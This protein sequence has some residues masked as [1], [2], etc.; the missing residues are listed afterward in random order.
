M[1]SPP[2]PSAAAPA[3]SPE[4]INARIAR[5]R[6]EHDVAEQNL[7]RSL[8][9]HEIGALEELAGDASAA[10]REQLDAVNVEPEFHEPLERLI[11]L[12]RRSGSS[13][14]VGKLL[15]RLS[16]VSEGADERARALLD[17]AAH[18][19]DVDCD[20]EAARVA[21]E[22]AAEEKPNEPAVFL[23]LE[24]VAA[25]LKDD[26]LRLR[27]LAARADLCTHPTWATLLLLD[28]AELERAQGDDEAALG[29]IEQALEKK[30]AATFR[31]LQA[32]EAHAQTTG[33]DDLT[34]RALEAQAQLIARSMADEKLGDA[35]GVP[36]YRRQ[37][38][39]AADASLR[40]AEAH[41]RRG[42]VA[43]A[44]TLLDQALGRITDEPALTHA[45]LV[46]AELMGDTQKSAE[47]ALSELEQG[48]KGPIAASLWLRV[49]EAA[50]TDGDAAR[51]IEAVRKALAEDPGSIAARVLELDLLGNG[52]DPQALATAYEAAAES[53]S[54]D[55][56][57]AR[58]FLLAADA[59]AR[60][61][62]DAPGAKAALSQAGMYGAS[63]LV[64]ARTTRM[65]ATLM[66]DVAWYEEGSR[67]LVAAHADPAEQVSVWFE[68]SRLRMLRQD[69][70]QHAAL[71]SLSET[72]HG[73]WLGAMLRAFVAPLAGAGKP[74]DPEAALA[75]LATISDAQTSRAIRVTLAL[76]A[77]DAKQTDAAEQLLA[78]L[79]RED[80][81]DVLT[82]SAL[83]ALTR[84]AGRPKD[85]AGVLATCASGCEDG[86]LSA[87]LELEAGILYWQA[88]ERSVAVEAFTRA[89]SLSPSAGGPVLGWALRAADPDNLDSRRRALEMTGEDDDGLSALERFGV[90]AGTGGDRLAA[91]ELVEVLNGSVEQ[92]FRNAALLAHALIGEQDARAQALEALIAFGGTTEAAARGA[93]H[94]RALGDADADAKLRTAESWA[95][96]DPA[97]APALEW[98]GAAYG[99]GNVEK[100]LE[101]RRTLA[102]RLEGPARLGVRASA[103]LCSYLGGNGSEPLLAD[104]DGKEQLTVRLTN[105]ELAPP[106]CDPRRRASALA[107]VEGAFGDESAAMARALAGW[108]LLASDD[109]DAAVRAFRSAV[110]AYPQELIGW[111]GLRVAADMMRDLP[112]LAEASAALGDAVHDDAR[113]AELWEQ[114]AFI[115]LDELRDPARAEF[116]LSRAVERDITRFKSFDKLFR[117]VREKKD[118]TRLLDLI[119][120]R[121]EVAED[122][123]EIAK[124]YWER[125]RVLRTAGDREGALDALENVVLLEPDHVGALALSGEIHLT[126][127]N[128]PE[129]AE[130]LARLSTLSEA[131]AKQ[132]LMS[133]VAAVD[134][135]ENKLGRL[136]QA[137]LVL[138]GLY[139][140]GLSTLPV[141]ERF[142][143]AA[144]KAESWRQA[145]EVLEQLMGER[146]TSEGRVEAAR[147]AMAIYR[148]R[149]DEPASAAAVIERLLS[150]APDDGEALELVMSGVLPRDITLRL[151]GQ[152][153]S[154]LVSGLMRDPM[155]AERVDRLARIAAKLDNAPL[156]QAALGSLVALGEGS[157]EMD[158]E[159]AV[160]DQRVA[161]VPQMA[162]DPRALPELADPEDAG[163][164]ADLMA[165]LATT[166][167]EA[168]GPGLAAFGLSKKDRVDP[169]AGLPVR[170]EIAAWAGA[171]GIGEFELYVGGQDENGFFAV[172]TEVPA[173]VVGRSV[174]APLSAA[175]RQMVARELFAL[176][177]GVTILRHREVT[178]V[179][180]L[181][182]ASCR[183]AGHDVPS[184]AYAMLG[185][186]QRLL[187][188]EM[189]R[190]VKKILPE[191]A[192]RVAGSGQDP[193]AWV[194]AATSSLDRLA[195]I[196]AG[197]VSW[198]LSGGSAIH[199]GQ[200]GASLE[201]QQ[202]TARLLSFVLSPTYLVLREQLGMGVR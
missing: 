45:R 3:P 38:T 42:D 122:P 187:G 136:D 48:A 202:R 157:P 25:Q 107:G 145:T 31:A 118:G 119:G 51:A 90:E 141:R 173:L 127:G 152:G 181:V 67:R 140:S 28:V 190:K 169:R 78:D 91:V 98:F 13:K 68:L 17:H 137:L 132:R 43:Q 196:A 23:A 37:N 1:N 114:S 74:G 198:V 195:A 76:R 147:L 81:S 75:T 2:A 21:L 126:S 84:T 14:N 16:Q 22:E 170:N 29:R 57:R 66:G 71:T 148:D 184:P 104:E 186:F 103:A 100:E 20:F 30:S 8:L 9:L 135:F 109:Y 69:R 197:D 33:R 144:A 178:D 129:A 82:A 191:L 143:R 175:H 110:E 11:Q 80:P 161:R 189:P 61:G 63:P 162:I 101:A 156:R 96:A 65:L 179:A 50:A 168:L 117:M 72:E 54:T 200:L 176:R 154:A 160:L 62:A 112:L 111:E 36:R 7:L 116:A 87:W 120:R 24:L 131:P 138:D 95:D 149:L 88:G 183:L 44:A 41:R 59:W 194:R 12:V 60:L 97:L 47:L 34:A 58:Y 164:V 146:E 106:G 124:L 77:L 10:A 86:E 70:D 102:D 123:E 171:L 113:G 125:A 134:I 130:K 46:I 121:L 83:A 105:L 182:V 15:E 177:R 151:L 158:R 53:M 39:Y 165:A 199:R 99:A 49:A 128:L 159:L 92:D 142:A 5:L 79:H 4:Q 172:A 35:L 155:D 163:P 52:H 26:A 27:A 150:E 55:E 153:Q 56:A 185:E 85:A 180:A 94:A 93:E 89:A 115:L 108:S 6:A 73:R 166:F 192:A 133:G 193:I 40:A 201:A 19:A 18:L 32:L 167:A 188:K 174:I 64:L 139:R